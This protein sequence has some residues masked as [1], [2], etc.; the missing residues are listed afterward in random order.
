MSVLAPRLR[1]VVTLQRYTSGQGSAG[2]EVKEWTD[3]GER[4]AGVE[5]ISG[6]E[7]FAAQQFN[8]ETT[9]R[10]VLRY[11]SVTAS[12]KARD[13]VLFGTRILEL[14]APA[15]NLRERNREVHLMCKE[16]ER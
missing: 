5:P 6:R 8:A 14:T 10:V 2:G 16:V 3:L 13:R 9:I 4:R 15:Q 12:M 7:W 11:D 1:H